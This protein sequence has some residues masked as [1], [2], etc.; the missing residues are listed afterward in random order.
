MD[1]GRTSS[2]QDNIISLALVERQFAIAVR[3]K[4][5]VQYTMIAHSSSLFLSLILHNILLRG[6]IVTKDLVQNP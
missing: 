4:T 2:G 5:R 1:T 6:T 3:K